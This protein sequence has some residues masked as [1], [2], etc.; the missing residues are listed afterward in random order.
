MWSLGGA[1]VMRK[2]AVALLRRRCS[3]PGLEVAG[4]GRGEKRTS[5][6]TSCR[7]TAAFDSTMSFDTCARE[8]TS[9]DANGWAVSE[10]VCSTSDAGVR[11]KLS[12]T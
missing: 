11:S 4:E 12:Q 10:H 1:E 8:A 3:G 6:P 2:E 9:F 5:S 7:S